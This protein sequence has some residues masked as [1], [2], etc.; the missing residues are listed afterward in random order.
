N[1]IRHAEESAILQAQGISLSYQRPGEA[2]NT[3]LRDFSLRLMPGEVIA[4]LGPSGVGKSSLLR[5]LA[6]LQQ[7][8]HGN[9]SVNGEPL[10]GPHP[11]SIFVFQ[12]PSLLPWLTLEENVAFGLDFRHQ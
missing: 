11:R 3:V 7:A 10:Q 9:V 8:D 4:I 12:D 5:V 1:T 6:G 2:P